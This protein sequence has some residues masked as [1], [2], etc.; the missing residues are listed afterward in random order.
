MFEEVQMPLTLWRQ[1]IIYM[2][3]TSYLTEMRETTCFALQLK[4]LS[5]LPTV[6]DQTDIV[7]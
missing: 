5:F 7:K 2:T 4:R 3:F 1:K 6:R